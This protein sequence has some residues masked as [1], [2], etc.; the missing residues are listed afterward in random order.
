MTWP[1]HMLRSFTEA[2]LPDKTISKEANLTE[3]MLQNEKTK[4]YSMLG[5]REN[6]KKALQSEHFPYI[7]SVLLRIFFCPCTF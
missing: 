2:D 1:L 4:C 7:S 6:A 5:Y 3:I